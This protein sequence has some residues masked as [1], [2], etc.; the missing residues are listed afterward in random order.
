MDKD[1]EVSF[2]EEEITKITGINNIL[3]YDK[4]AKYNS[5]EALLG[6]HE[7]VVILYRTT[8]SYGHW[9]TLFKVN[10]NTLEFFDSLGFKVDEEFTFIDKEV[11]RGL[12]EWIPH[13][14]AILKKSRYNIIQNKH[15]LQ[16][17]KEGIN[18]C[19]RWVSARLYLRDTPL[20]VFVKHFT[21][22]LPRIKPDVMITIY[23][24]N[25]LK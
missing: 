21:S 15:K 17:N 8:N 23:T 18:T 11:R 19:G 16:E 25:L 6:I 12:G 22:G 14:S 20:N 10:N 4:L 13:L 1:E 5:V 7:A 2:G 3:T 9:T 24:N